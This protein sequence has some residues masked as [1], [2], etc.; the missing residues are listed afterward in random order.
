MSNDHQ[1]DRIDLPLAGVS[2][3]FTALPF[4][5][6]T[7]AATNEAPPEGPGVGVV[8]TEVGG[9]V[10]HRELHVVQVDRGGR[11]HLDPD[12]VPA[13][14]DP[15]GEERGRLP[16]AERA[17]RRDR[18][19]LGDAVD[20]DSH[21]LCRAGVRE[22][23]GDVEVARAVRVDRVPGGIRPRGSSRRCSS[24]PRARCRPRPGGTPHPR[25]PQWCPR[26]RLCRSPRTR[27]GRARRAIAGYGWP[28]G[29]SAAR[30]EPV[31][32]LAVAVERELARCACR[33]RAGSGSAGSRTRWPSA[34]GS[35]WP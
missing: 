29:P 25:W 5:A 26:S 27:P 30:L 8:V 3:N 18:E 35:S 33:P 24:S 2:V 20:A 7:G 32:V 11:A 19:G 4:G 14:G 9:C 21:G 22:P 31:E 15:A 13:R 16:G 1:A 6:E 17:R 28:A 34:S 23:E 10:A 12:R